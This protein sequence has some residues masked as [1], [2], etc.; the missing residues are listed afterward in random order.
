MKKIAKAK[1]SRNGRAADTDVL[2]AAKGYTAAGL[3]VIPIARGGDKNPTEKWT[4]YKSRLATP[5]ELRHWFG[6]K[7]PFGIAVVCGKVSGHLELLDFDHRA[8]EVFASWCELVEAECPGLVA[9]LCVVRTPRLPDGGFHVRYRCPD[10]AIPGNQKLAVEPIAPVEGEGEGRFETLIETRGEGGYALAPGSPGECHETGGTYEHVS[11]PPLTSLP[12]VTAAERDVLISCAWVFDL[13]PHDPPEV[14][15]AQPPGGLRPGDDFNARGPTWRELLEPLGWAVS[16]QFGDV[17]YWRRPGKA[18]GTSATTG[19]CRSRSGLD[20]FAVFSSNA[21]PFD[22]PRCGRTCTTYTKFAAYALLHHHGDFSAAARALAAQGYGQP[23]PAGPFGGA[24]QTGAAEASEVALGPLTLRPVNPRRTGSGKLV[25]AAEVYRGG[26]LVTVVQVCSTASS[27]E[28]PA[29]LLAQLS[30]EGDRAAARAALAELVGRAAQL[31]A[32]ARPQEGPLLREV[33]ADR[34][35]EALQLRHRTDRG[36]WSESQGREVGR[37][38]FTTYLP[39]WLIDRAAVAADAPRDAT[40]GVVRFDLV[41]AIRSELEVVWSDLSGTLPRAAD[42]DLGADTE[43]ARRFREAM[44]RLWTRTQTFEVTRAEQGDVAAR[45][46]LISRVRTAYKPYVAAQQNPRGREQWREVQRAFSAW[47]RPR[48]TN[49]GELRVLLAM[50]WELV[51]QIGVELPGVTD[52]A[53]LTRL[54]ERFE[55]LDPSPGV[56]STLSGGKARLAV[57]SPDL[58]DALM[59]NPA[60]NRSPGWE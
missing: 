14:E 29:R 4:P 39:S 21:A 59:E 19:Y 48:V 43:A 49:G 18:R 27:L 10:V 52:Q 55:V 23:G 46:S 41:R 1:P 44:I 36:L 28:Q 13:E 32:L 7:V 50:R 56:A 38:E 60:G 53:S 30:P 16:R 54:G 17:V 42:T 51:G 31:L 9:R 8:A 12:V 24:C 11:G 15:P 57:L 45:A 2:A 58:T 37:A 34:V 33:V 26:L 5:G 22:G 25:V 47:W 6:R 40:G 3:S 20:L 35:V